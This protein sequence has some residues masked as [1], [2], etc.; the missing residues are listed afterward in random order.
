MSKVLL[1]NKWFDT[2]DKDYQKK[3][4]EEIIKNGC[5]RNDNLL[6][7]SVD[8]AK[9]KDAYCITDSKNFYDKYGKIICDKESVADSYKV[10]LLDDFT[11]PDHPVL[12]KGCTIENVSVE[13]AL[14]GNERHITCIVR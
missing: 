5:P 10:D 6:T 3:L 11:D 8:H 9:Q 12:Y 7:V 14:D 2:E 4:A 1:N 13:D